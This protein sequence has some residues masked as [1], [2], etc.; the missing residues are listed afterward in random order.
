MKDVPDLIVASISANGSRRCMAS[1]A[2]GSIATPDNTSLRTLHGSLSIGLLLLFHLLSCCNG[3]PVSDAIS[4][5]TTRTLAM[6]TRFIR[7]YP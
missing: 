7:P 6:S 2:V 4:G 1:L 5:L 3:T